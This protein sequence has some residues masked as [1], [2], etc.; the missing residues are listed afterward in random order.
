M[1]TAYTLIE[2]AEAR[3]PHHPRFALWATY[4]ATAHLFMVNYEAGLEVGKRSSP[5]N[6]KLLSTAI[7]LR[8]GFRWVGR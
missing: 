8:L 3:A 5:A 4:R 2:T 7:A 6:A 1:K